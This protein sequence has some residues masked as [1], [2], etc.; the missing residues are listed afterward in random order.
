MATV[1]HYG[2]EQCYILVLFVGVDG[3]RV[4]GSSEGLTGV[5]SV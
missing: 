5:I 4:G 2:R 1:A 3:C